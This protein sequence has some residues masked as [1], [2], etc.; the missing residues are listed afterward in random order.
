VTETWGGIRWEEDET[1]PEGTL[2]LTD[3]DTGRVIRGRPEL[4]ALVRA[5]VLRG[6]ILE[7]IGRDD[8]PGAQKGPSTA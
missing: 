7:G 6:V 2:L 3:R 5:G 8:P 4:L 1:F